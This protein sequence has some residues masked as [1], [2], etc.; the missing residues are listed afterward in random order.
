MGELGALDPSLLPRKL[1]PWNTLPLSVHDP[2][3]GYLALCE[4]VRGFQNART[5]VDMDAFAIGIQEVLKI[6]SVT[7]KDGNATWIRFSASEQSL[8][9]P[10]LTSRYKVQAPA[11]TVWPEIIFG[12]KEATSHMRWAALWASKL[13]MKCT[14]SKAVVLFRACE[15]SIKRD[16]KVLLFF[17]QYILRK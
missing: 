4:I 13:I 17:L 15:P 16:P 1:K 10:M 2:E 3:F 11:R 14:D 8:L 9:R 6:Y 12:T 5:S 7:E